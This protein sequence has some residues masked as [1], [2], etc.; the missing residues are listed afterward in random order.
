MKILRIFILI[1]WFVVIC[2]AQKAVLIG[3][4]YD[5]NGA[6][7][8]N[9]KI[10]AINQIGE[11]FE[12][13]TNTEGAYILKLP[14]KVYY[15]QDTSNFRISTYEI[16]ADAVGFERFVLKNFKFVPV[17][18]LKMN[19]DIALDVGNQDHEPCGYGGAG[20]LCLTR[21]PIE[22]NNSKPSNKILLKPLERLPKRKNKNKRKR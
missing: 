13:F 1:C 20:E 9:A 2:K 18:N 3:T 17:W 12:A 22:T 10:T 4:V 21:T 16:V 7:I 5:A 15:S 11:K 14:F 6:V 19:L 8:V